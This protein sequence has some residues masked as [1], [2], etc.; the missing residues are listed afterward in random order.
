MGAVRALSLATV[1]AAASGFIVISIGT[2]AL[3]P[4]DAASFQAYW[5]LFFALAGLLDGLMLETTRST[6]AA[7]MKANKARQTGS[8]AAVEGHAQL[9]EAGLGKLAYPWRF[10]GI[11][12]GSVCAVILLSGW[13]WMPLLIESTHPIGPIALLGVGLVSYAYQATLSGVLSGLGL[14]R[15]YALLIALDAVVRLVL[16][17]AFWALGFGLLGFCVITVIGAASWTLL[18]RGVPRPQIDV[19]PQLFRRHVYSAM[20]ASGSSAAMITGFPVLVQGTFRG[21][22]G[23][24]AIILAVTL[25]RAPILVP[26]QRF[27]SALTVRFVQAERAIYRSLAAPVGL[28]LGAGVVGA[29]AA[30][31]L[32]PWIL[33]IVYAPTYAMPGVILA[34]LTF[35][36][37]CTGAL[38]VTGT[39]TL[40][41]EKHAWYVAGWVAASLGAL[42]ILLLP[43]GL[44]EAV[45]AALIIAPAVGAGIHMW[46][47]KDC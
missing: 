11:V 40:A 4:V 33:S 8:T 18:L 1:I 29:A 3:S 6:S 43:L 39:A 26:L 16:S 32:G 14:W 42:G 22:V 37:S 34:V 30:W 12:G 24:A 10:A 13:L 23:V 38:M 20:V 35:A 27:Q 46:A 36:S 28:V 47:L 17:L 45:C 7:R 15:R 25:T 21:E 2:W 19:S 9:R 5:G 31:L 44:Y 41:K